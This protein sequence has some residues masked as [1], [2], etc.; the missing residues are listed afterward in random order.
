MSQRI[1][2]KPEDGREKRISP[3]S[4]EVREDG[5]KPVKVVG[6]AAIF[7]KRSVN[8]GSDT[9][10]FYE[11]IQPGAFAGV[12]SD[13][14]RAV[15]DHSGGLQTLARTKSGTLQLTEDEIGLR[16]EFEAPDTTAGRDIV[17]ILKRGDIDQ[18]S[19]A[20]SVNKDGS[21]FEDIE[22]NGKEVTIRT[23]TKVEKL[24]DVS[25]VTYPAY[26]DTIVQARSMEDFLNNKKLCARKAKHEARARKIK[27]AELETL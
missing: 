19:F 15:I 18:S 4:F 16:F 21:S 3:A 20:F 22:E 10:P 7:N 23:I 13:D 5:D 25:P 24:F 12:I 2:L 27:L 14:V 11:I 17:K 1:T 8:F 9:Y 26:P 6:Y